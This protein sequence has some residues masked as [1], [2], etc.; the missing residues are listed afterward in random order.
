[1]RAALYIH[2]YEFYLCPRQESNLEPTDYACHYD[3]RRAPPCGQSLWSGLSLRLKRLPLSL[4]TFPAGERTGL[5]SG[6]PSRFRVAGFP[7]FDRFY[8]RT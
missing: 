2:V 1:M 8:K 5:G 7:E 3:F 4:Y 6:L